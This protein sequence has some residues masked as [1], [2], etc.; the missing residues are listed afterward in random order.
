MVRSSKIRANDLA[1]IEG[2]IND[3][4]SVQRSMMTMMSMRGGS[5]SVK[6]L[7]DS[8]YR[9]VANGIAPSNLIKLNVGQFTHRV[10]FGIH[11]VSPV[12]LRRGRA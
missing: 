9:K 11:F 5:L 10:L 8:S 2:N 4:R 7:G 12:V 1:D 3:C 6:R